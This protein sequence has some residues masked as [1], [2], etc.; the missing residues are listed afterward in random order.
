M[1][2]PAADET[3]LWLIELV[4][5]SARRDGFVATLS[6][7]ERDRMAR[8]AYARDRDAFAVRR[9]VLRVLLAGYLGEAPAAIELDETCPTCGAP[10]GKPRLAREH[11][12]R[13]STSRSAGRAL[14]AVGLDADLG[15]DLERVDTTRDWRGPARLTLAPSERAALEAAPEH[16]RAER[17]YRWWARK[18]A[19]AKAT[20]LGLRL[21]LHEIETT[22][23]GALLALPQAAGAPS[24][25]WLRDLEAGPGFA[26][27]VAAKGPERRLEGVRD[28]AEFVPDLTIR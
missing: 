6:A 20:G 25:W 8:F 9:G 4:P 16:E 3:H 19:L 24:D 17:F 14:I 5:L 21:P 28:V 13:F 15:V 18:E 2:L 27:A 22:P 10:H 11:R 12:L 1:R 23:A 7:S 26:A